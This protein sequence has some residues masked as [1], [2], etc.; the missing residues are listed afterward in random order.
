MAK[1]IVAIVGRPN[2]GKSSLFNRLVGE[3][4]A[5][6]EDTPGITRDRV[7]G[8]TDWNGREFTVVDTGGLGMT[9]DD[10]FQKVIREQA[11]M[12]IEE[13]DVILFL[14]D[15]IEGLSPIDMDLA[16]MLRRTP[17]PVLVL[18]NKADNT[19]REQETPEFYQL[20]LGEV[21]PVAAH[22]GRGVADMLDALV[23][24]L[25]PETEEEEE[26]DRIR[27]SIVGR[28][29]VGKSSLLN[30]ILGEQRVIVSEIPGTTRDPI[31]VPFD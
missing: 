22:H 12:A 31:D 27:V 6:V 19:R 30:A 23:A 18:A 4:V 3:R 5:I 10:P 25:P 28:P 14:G 7:H 29:N 13:A 20:G 11:E 2:V 16:E 8:E 24:L 1:P 17:K 26:T 21:Y 9:S 15:A